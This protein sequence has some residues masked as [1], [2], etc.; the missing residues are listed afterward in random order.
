MPYSVR[1]HADST[2][3]ECREFWGPAGSPR[4]GVCEWGITAELMRPHIA[5]G[6]RA[7]CVEPHM[8][9]LPKK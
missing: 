2:E 8:P 9:D 5:T 4:I 3:E 7:Y 6:E 1:F